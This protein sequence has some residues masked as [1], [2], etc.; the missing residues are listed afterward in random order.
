MLRIRTGTDTELTLTVLKYCSKVPKALNGLNCSFKHKKKDSLFN[1]IQRYKY[2]HRAEVSDN[3][4]ILGCRYRYLSYYIATYLEKFCEHL[5][6][7][8]GDEPAY[9]FYFYP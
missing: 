1:N 6:H 2:N 3:Y 9:R 7:N 8:N 5:L 4:I